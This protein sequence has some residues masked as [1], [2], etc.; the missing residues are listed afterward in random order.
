[1]PSFD[2]SAVPLAL[3]ALCE[4]FRQ[5]GYK[6]WAVGG[7]VRDV[8]LGRP[9]AD[10]DVATTALPGQVCD[11]FR[12]VIP[13]G[14]DHGTVT[15]IWEK[16]PY[17][18]TTL[19]SERGYTDGR[20]PDQ[21]TFVEHIEE[22]LARRDFT[23]NAM[24]YDPL[25]ETLVDPYSGIQ[26]IRD[27]RLRTVG[28][29]F[30]RFS[31]DGLRV[32]RAA[33]FVATLEF[34]LD[35]ATEAAIAPSLSVYRK[36]AHERVRDEW[37]KCMAANKPSLGFEVM[38]RTGILSV[39]L[40]ELLG[41]VGCE[42]N[43]WHAYDVWKHTLEC[44]DA[45]PSADVTV[46]MAG[47]LHDLGKPQTRAV[48]EKTGDYTF[49]HHE[50][51]GADIADRWLQDYRFP[52][53]DRARIV[54]LIRH[55]L[56]CYA[57]EWSDAAVRRFLKRVGIE[58]VA[59]LLQLARADVLAKGRPVQEELKLLDEL[60]RRIATVMDENQPLSVR[61]LAINGRDLMQHCA[62]K[63]GPLIGKVL[64]ML[65][66]KVLEDPSLNQQEILLAQAAMY[67]KEGV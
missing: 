7:A 3:I 18:V 43:R 29:P 55:H 30:L 25:T 28:D 57:S 33:R 41:Q 62:L 63:P 21:V 24:A 50:T 11:V 26:D 35:K 52:N 44:V 36:V 31:E 5:H 9:V 14:I 38:Q 17:E 20:R 67:L 64:D 48:S 47:L 6:A 42:Q 40:P 16:K 46:R 65:L 49:Y 66:E 10:W 58:Y 22:D 2:A 1:M 23:V 27:R 51:L 32:V 15:V 13:T 53:A 60:E 59:D 19:R 61:D 34:A 54:A 4:R 39:T 37:L 45:L 8:C 56:I 12:R